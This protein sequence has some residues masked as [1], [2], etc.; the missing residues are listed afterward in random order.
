MYIAIVSEPGYGVINFE[1][2]IIFI[3]KMFFYKIKNARQRIKYL[4]NDRAFKVK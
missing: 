1:S 4:E 3:T 2:N